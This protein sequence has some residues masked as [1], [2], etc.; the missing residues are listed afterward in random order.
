V[1]AFHHAADCLCLH[2]STMGLVAVAL[3]RPSTGGVVPRDFQAGRNAV[4]AGGSGSDPEAGRTLTSFEVALGLMLT[5]DETMS[6]Y[7]VG[8]FVGSLAKKSINRKL[9]LA[10]TRLAPKELQLT[11]I[12]FG[13]LPLYSYD[14]D[15]DFPPVARALKEAIAA[16]DAVLFVTP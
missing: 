9:A 2:V 5:G 6:N 16:V 3:R 10:L 8:Y 15:A 11:E 7:N 13:D 4:Q 14:Y 1:T 12:P